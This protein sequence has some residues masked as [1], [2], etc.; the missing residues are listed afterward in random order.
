M[1]KI[2]AFKIALIKITTFLILIII[3][4]AKMFE[5]IVIKL[6]I[7][8]NLNIYEYDFYENDNDVIKALLEYKDLNVKRTLHF[9]LNCMQRVCQIEYFNIFYQCF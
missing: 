6:G 9:T 1:Y 2:L 4:I 5:Y 7:H 8:Q 3:I